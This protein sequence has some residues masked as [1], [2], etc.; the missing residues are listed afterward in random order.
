MYILKRYCLYND[1]NGD[2][3]EL[4]KKN[5]SHLDNQ[6]SLYSYLFAEDNPD[7]EK[8]MLNLII[9]RQ[10]KILK[11]KIVARIFLV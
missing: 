7:W 3:T 5:C 9:I 4:E 11:S 8:T 6:T 1:E 10:R 2:E